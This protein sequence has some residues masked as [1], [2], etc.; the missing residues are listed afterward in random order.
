[1]AVTIGVD[2]A[3][4]TSRL[5]IVPVDGGEP[6][7]LMRLTLPRGFARRPRNIAWVPDGSAVVVQTESIDPTTLDI[8]GRDHSELWMVPVAG[9][10][11]RKLDI[12]VDAWHRGSTEWFGAGFSLAPDGKRIAFLTGKASAE[13]WALENFLPRAS[14]R[15]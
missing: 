11:P 5:T 9:G 14:T 1:L 2:A 10:A 7:E 15:P 8:V 6:R 12:D 4:K 13:V 3:T